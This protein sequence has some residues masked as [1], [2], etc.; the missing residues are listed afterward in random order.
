[1]NNIPEDL[2]K[3][4]ELYNFIEAEED[5]GL[6][7]EDFS[8]NN[9]KEFIENTFKKDFI[10]FR[11]AYLLRDM[12][13]VRF[14]AHKFKGSFKYLCSKEISKNCEVIQHFIDSGNIFDLNKY[15][16]KTVNNISF[17]LQEFTIFSK[18]INMPINEQQLSEF[19]ELNKECDDLEDIVN[20]STITKAE[21]DIQEIT[22]DNKKVRQNLCCTH[23]HCILY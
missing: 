14:Y 7:F 20:R 6:D 8:T 4:G 22:M 19:W 13:T 17:F 18:Q 16:L 9:F 12:K 21:L 5:Y 3:N 11:K 15:Y 1:M 2:L 10:A 23:Q